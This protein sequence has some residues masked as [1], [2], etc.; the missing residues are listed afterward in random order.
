MKKILLVGL[1]ALVFVF[2]V[3]AD[4][5]AT[6]PTATPPT[7]TLNLK[8]NIAVVNRIAITGADRPDYRFLNSDDTGFSSV[9]FDVKDAFGKTG[10]NALTVAHLHYKTNNANRVY[11][12]MNGDELKNQ[13][14]N[15]HV[16]PYTLYYGNAFST[17]SVYFKKGYGSDNSTNPVIIVDYQTG[18][19]MVA[20]S[21]PLKI[22]IDNGNT[23]SDSYPAGSYKAT[24]TFTLTAI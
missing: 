9:E 11:V 14:N 8:A 23:T 2:G 18:T 16:I 22:V 5:P 17:N 6:P 1:L 13:T 15:S 24:I 10:E 4:E 19:P 21:N 12:S 3:F 20:V 7:A